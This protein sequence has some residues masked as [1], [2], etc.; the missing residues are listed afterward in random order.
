MRHWSTSPLTGL[1]NPFMLR[2]QGSA[3][4]Y[5]GLRVLRRSAAKLAISYLPHKLTLILLSIF[6]AAI[7]G[8][9][10]KAGLSSNDVDYVQTTFDL[11]RTRTMIKPGMDSLRVK[12]MLDTVYRRHH[13]SRA[14]YLKQTGELGGDPKRAEAVYNAIKDSVGMK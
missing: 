12:S 11:M 14:D 4:L 1:L 10:N 5:P 2:T 3:S 6:A 9:S 13:T 8:C 7:L